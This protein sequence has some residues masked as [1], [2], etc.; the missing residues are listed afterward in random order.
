M[1]VIIDELYNLTMVT[2]IIIII[3]E[4]I[5]NAKHVTTNSVC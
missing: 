4:N 5:E 1:Y 3:T 2:R